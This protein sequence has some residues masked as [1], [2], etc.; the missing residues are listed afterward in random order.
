VSF[1]Q[2]MMRDKGD[3]VAEVRHMTLLLW[4]LIQNDALVLGLN[5]TFNLPSKYLMTQYTLWFKNCSFLFHYHIQDVGCN[6]NSRENNHF[7][8]SRQG[9]VDK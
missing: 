8:K 4:A 5:Y 3:L 1:A 7:Q 2:W 9:T 6:S